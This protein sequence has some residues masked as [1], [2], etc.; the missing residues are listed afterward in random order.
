MKR[1][2]RPS[3]IGFGLLI[4]VVVP[5]ITALTSKTQWWEPFLIVWGIIG[6]FVVFM[7]AMH[8]LD[9]WWDGRQR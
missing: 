6:G 8:R 3:D 1:R 2:L 4:L 9:V 7:A 5:L